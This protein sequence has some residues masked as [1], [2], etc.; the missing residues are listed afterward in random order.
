[1][2]IDTFNKELEKRGV[3]DFRP[4]GLIPSEF[5]QLYGF[6]TDDDCAGQF[7]ISVG[8]LNACKDW[9]E[10]LL[11]HVDHTLRDIERAKEW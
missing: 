4:M 1:M 3:R 7:S 6:L 10:Y 11:L 5:V 2:D 9:Y 8:E